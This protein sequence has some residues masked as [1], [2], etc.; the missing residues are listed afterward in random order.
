MGTPLSSGSYTATAFARHISAPEPFPNPRRT[1]RSPGREYSRPGPVTSHLDP[2][3]RA[4]VPPPRKD[5]I[6]GA[7]TLEEARESTEPSWLHS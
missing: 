6:G 4:S 7:S 3:T 2:R 1:S 5:P